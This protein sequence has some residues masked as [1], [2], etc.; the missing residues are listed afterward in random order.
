MRWCR[1]LMGWMQR[2]PVAL[3][4]NLFRE[5]QLPPAEIPAPAL[6]FA[7]WTAAQRREF[8]LAALDSLDVPL[9]TLEA[10]YGERVDAGQLGD[11]IRRAAAFSD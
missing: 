10:T 4:A 6:P 3:G 7:D 11:L 9:S 8:A 2:S 5:M 1:D